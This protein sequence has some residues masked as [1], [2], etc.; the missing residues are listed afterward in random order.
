MESSSIVIRGRFHSYSE[1]KNILV[2]SLHK[3]STAL[4]N[5]SLCGT[6]LKEAMKY[7]SY[8]DEVGVLA[9][10]VKGEGKYCDIQADKIT[11]MQ[12]P[13]IEKEVS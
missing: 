12:W 7:L 8:G 11:F 13:V 9:C 10:F 3:D 2:V 4:V 6:R 1:D 5:I